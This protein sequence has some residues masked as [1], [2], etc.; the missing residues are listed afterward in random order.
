MKLKPSFSSPLS[1]SLASSTYKYKPKC[2]SLIFQLF[3]YYC[4][5]LQRQGHLWLLITPWISFSLLCLCAFGHPVL[6]FLLP[7]HTFETVLDF[8]NWFK[9]HPPFGAFTSLYLVQIFYCAPIMCQALCPVL[10]LWDWVRSPFPPLTEDITHKN[11]FSPLT[12]ITL[13]LCFT[14]DT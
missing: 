9:L 8:K 2:S 6:L 7:L 10:G 3:P 11:G 4:I 1:S 14:F 13:S 5:S 12:P